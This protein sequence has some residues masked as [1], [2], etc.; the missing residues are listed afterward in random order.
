M[1]IKLNWDATLY[2]AWAFVCIIACAI[3]APLLFYQALLRNYQ[4][5]ILMN[6]YR[7]FWFEFAMVNLS[8]IGGLLLFIIGMVKY[9]RSQ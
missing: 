9:G 4:I 6:E 3:A 2:F 1:G 7:E 8:F 5:T